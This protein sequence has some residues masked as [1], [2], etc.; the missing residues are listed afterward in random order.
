[1]SIDWIT[2]A[3]QIANFLVL[4]WLLKRFLYRP[5]LDGIDARETE[6]ANRMQDAVLAQEKAA[7]AEA[8][9]RDQ[10]SRQQSKEADLSEAVR[11]AAEDERD[12]ILAEARAQLERE[13]ALWL[14]QL[15]D[16][17]REYTRK[18]HRVGADALL[19]LTRKALGDLADDTLEARMAA[20]LIQKIDP[21]AAE[22]KNAA[23][24]ASSAVI[25]SQAPLP[26][27]VKGSLTSGL[28]AVFPGIA[29]DFK[30]DPE[31]APGL[32]LRIGGAQLA[33]TLDSY[34]DGLEALVAD[35]LGAGAVPGDPDHA[36]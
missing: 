3:A 30:T 1:M 28:D 9:Y 33:W 22:L 2:V 25:Y 36:Q 27:G 17:A 12:A 16:E 35:K 10:L 23:A 21:M 26:P 31:Q 7:Q 14:T 5:I 20:Q 29:P 4:V 19:S 6:I 15:S 24:A 11:K 32:V 13:R 18:L 34:I 8:D